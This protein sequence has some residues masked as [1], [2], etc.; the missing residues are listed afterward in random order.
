MTF[1]IRSCIA[2]RKVMEGKDLIAEV[3]VKIVH[4]VCL[5]SKQPLPSGPR[6]SESEIYRRDIT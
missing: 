4:G 3:E 5:P 2:D 6:D 1:D